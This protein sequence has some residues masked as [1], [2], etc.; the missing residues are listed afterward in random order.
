MTGIGPAPGG[1]GV[2]M[3]SEMAEQPGVLEALVRSREATLDQVRA[4]APAELV[5]LVLLARGSSDNA[6]RHARYLLQQATGRPVV[7]AAPSLWTRYQTDMSLRGWVAVAVSQSG[8]TPE[9]GAALASMRRAGAS[10]V[11]VT[12][13]GAS[14]LAHVADTTVVLGAGRERAVPAT[15]TVTASVLALVH[16]AAALGRVPWGA[17]EEERAV[18]AVRAVLRDDAEARAAMEGLA[19]RELV[20]LGRG[21]T[22]AVALEGALKITEATLRGSRAY[23]SG[24]FLHGPVASVGRGAGVVAYAAAGPTWADVVSAAER[25]RSQGASL[26]IVTDRPPPASARGGA[27]VLEVRAG[28][29][30]PLVALPMIVRAQ[31]LALHATLALDLD[32]DAPAGLTKVTSTR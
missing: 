12:N 30:E 17:A 13:E 25:P 3:R 24:D 15:K 19:G 22:F 18:E 14:E 31:Q 28:L 9:I 26:L 16:V 21:F 29:P 6:A 1:P 23:A 32:P 2:L 27:Q 4:V 8:S 7:L 5:G 20:H 10:T 11:A